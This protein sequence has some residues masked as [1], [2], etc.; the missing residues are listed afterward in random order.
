MTKA[1]DAV[2]AKTKAEP[3]KWYSWSM[4]QLALGKEWWIFVSNFKVIYYKLL[5]LNQGL[6][7]AKFL[8]WMVVT[9]GMITALPLIFEVMDSILV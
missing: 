7:W 2:N 6:G 8:G 4:S 5:I 9:T 3:S 1:R